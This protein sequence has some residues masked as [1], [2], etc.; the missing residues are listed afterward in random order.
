MSSEPMH[1]WSAAAAACIN[2]NTEHR[3]GTV[4]A[5]RRW[6]GHVWH[7]RTTGKARVRFE[8]YPMVQVEPLE[9]WLDIRELTPIYPPDGHQ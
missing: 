8:R 6:D 5:V 4:V 1:T 9:H 7:T 3:V 2:W